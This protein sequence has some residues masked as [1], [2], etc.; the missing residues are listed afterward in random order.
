MFKKYNSFF[1]NW[2]IIDLQFCVGFCL[3]TMQIC[4]NCW[5]TY[6]SLPPLPSPQPTPLGHQRVPGWAPVLFSNF[7]IAMHFTHANAYRSMLLSRF[8]P[9]SY[10]GVPESVSSYSALVQVQPWS[11]VSCPHTPRSHAPPVEV[12]DS[13]WTSSFPGKPT[14]SWVL[15]GPQ[16]VPTAMGPLCSWQQSAQQLY[17]VSLS[18]LSHSALSFNLSPRTISQVTFTQ[19]LFLGSALRGI[20]TSDTKEMKDQEPF[21]RSI[22][23]SP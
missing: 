21:R 8:S 15:C 7:P 13:R 11:P 5:Y 1:K 20:L 6:V 18:F 2:R 14:L 4:H 9:L 3:T 19:I 22:F 23:E 16:A 12:G 10:L 17:L